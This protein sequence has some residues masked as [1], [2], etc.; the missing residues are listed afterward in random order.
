MKQLIKYEFRNLLGN[1][2]GIFF[3]IAFPI[4]MTNI[5]HPV[6]MSK[7]PEAAQ[8]SASVQIYITN[9]L[10]V[11]L[12]MMFVGFSALFSQELE[13]DVTI[14]MQLFGINESQQ[15]KAKMVAQGLSVVVGISIYSLFTLP[16]LN[17]PKPT[18]FAVISLVIAIIIL[19]IILFILSF[20][21]ALLAKKFSVTYGITMTL[22][23]G[24]M[25]FSG[26]MGIETQDL[27]KV[28]QYISKGFPTSFIVSDFK[29]VWTLTSYNF[30]PLI[31]SLLFFGAVSGLVCY[32]ALAQRK[33]KLENF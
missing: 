16:I 1:F 18:I 23:F 11:P 15:M 22:Y 24:M 27:P 13:N 7:V 12:A 2:F 3:G 33:R 20:S 5:L 32:G 10:M 25:V 30:A 29:E 8:G 9:L 31:Q 21:I 6:I 4:L 17:L 28:F 26:M 14:R 19:S